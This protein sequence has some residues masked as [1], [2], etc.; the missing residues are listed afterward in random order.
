MRL[1]KDY[2]FYEYETVV[3]HGGKYVSIKLKKSCD[4][5]NL[6]IS[7][8][9]NINNLVVDNTFV[10]GET[11]RSYYKWLGKSLTMTIA[12]NSVSLSKEVPVAVYGK[13]RYITKFGQDS[14]RVSVNADNTYNVSMRLVQE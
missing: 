9:V 2:H 3:A 5:S 12:S 10:N 14:V 11:L 6:T 8:T 13:I 7:S 1:Q 4:L